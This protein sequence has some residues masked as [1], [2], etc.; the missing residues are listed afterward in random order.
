MNKDDVTTLFKN[1]EDRFDTEEPPINHHSRF[2]ERLHEQQ[3]RS[4]NN[5]R[6]WI[7]PLSIAASVVLIVMVTLTRNSTPEVKDLAD[8]SPEMEQTQEFFALAIANELSKIEEKTS[9]EN[10]KLV[11]DALARLE[12]LEAS[13]MELKKDLVNSG[14]DKRVIHAMIENFQKRIELLEYVSE[15]IDAIQTLNTIQPTAL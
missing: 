2:M 13:Y 4:K 5:R 1:L 3:G 8:V 6:K 15:Q 9:P 10:Q 12:V 7:K 11:D 14:E